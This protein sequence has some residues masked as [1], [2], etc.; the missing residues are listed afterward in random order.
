MTVKRRIL[1]GIA[2]LLM[3]VFAVMCLYPMVWLILG[4]FKS[5]QELYTNTWGLPKSLGLV[6][7]TVQYLKQILFT[8][9]S[10][11]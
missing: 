10:V 9:T 6:N 2:F 7:Y 4:S 3:A 11:L 1:R 5:N 8:A